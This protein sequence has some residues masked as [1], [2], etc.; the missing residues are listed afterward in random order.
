MA[1]TV[2]IKAGGYNPDAA[3]WYW[4]KY[5]PNG[6]VAQK[7]TPMGLIRLAG[8]P[9]GCIECHSGAAGDDYLF[10]NDEM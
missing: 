8:K 9:K 10:F 6:T 7:Q 5:L 2:M 4:I 3:N 1:I